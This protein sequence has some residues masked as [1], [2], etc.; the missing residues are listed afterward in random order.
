MNKTKSWTSTEENSLNYSD[1]YRAPVR[2]GLHCVRSC[3]NAFLKE[4]ASTEGQGG[5]KTQK[6]LMICPKHTYKH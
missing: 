4:L 2:S 1:I 3:T 5:W 6:M